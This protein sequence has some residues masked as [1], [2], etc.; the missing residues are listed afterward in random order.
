MTKFYVASKSKHGLMWQQWRAQGVQ[1][2]SRWID[3]WN[4]GRF[5]KEQQTQHWDDI[6][7]DI[8][9][10]DALVLYSEEGEVQKGALGEWGMAFALGKALYYVGPDNNEIFTGLDHKRVIRC[11]SL[12]QVFSQPSATPIPKPSK[13]RVGYND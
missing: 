5:S 3:K 12:A 1:I 6:L 7:D 2:T 11:A 13:D 4:G 10:C 8:R 9:N